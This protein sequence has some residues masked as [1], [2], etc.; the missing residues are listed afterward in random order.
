[1]P[2]SKKSYNGR[3]V[4]LLTG[5]RTLLIENQEESTVPWTVYTN[6]EGTDQNSVF[7]EIELLNVGYGSGTEITYTC[8]GVANIGTLTR[9]TGDY[10]TGTGACR[11][12]ATCLTANNEISVAFSQEQSTMYIP[13]E[14][15]L[16]VG[17]GAPGALINM[18][19]PP[20]SR[21]WCAMYTNVNYNLIFTDEL[22]VQIYNQIITPADRVFS[23]KFFHP[24]NARMSVTTTAAAQ[25]FIIS[26]YQCL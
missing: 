14:S 8:S 25:R 16:Y 13:P 20:F 18:G 21:Y 2:N 12:F 1:M 23:T 19:Y 4:A 7:I 22:G 5:V 3:R 26:H 9:G 10:Y 6:V 15:Y 17:G 11:I 24:P